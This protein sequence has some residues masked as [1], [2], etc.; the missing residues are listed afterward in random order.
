VRLFASYRERV[1]QAE[2]ALD[3]PEGA[4]A[5]SLAVQMAAR[6]PNLTRDPDKLVVAVNQEYRDH[7][8][9]LSDEDEVALIP[10]VSG[11]SVL[12]RGLQ[13]GPHSQESRR[14]RP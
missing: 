7:D 12:G 10:P 4:T 13:A 14:G 3:L 9:P 2:L 1:G 5:G 8:Y 6:F 11:G